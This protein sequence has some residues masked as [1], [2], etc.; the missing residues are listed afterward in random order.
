MSAAQRKSFL[1]SDTASMNVLR[2]TIRVHT[3]GGQVQQRLGL[4][5]GFIDDLVTHGDDWSF[6][7]KVS[8]LVET[9]VSDFLNRTI[10]QPALATD[11]TKL[12]LSRKIQWARKL[13][14]IAGTRQDFVSQLSELR[15]QLAHNIQKVPSFRL[16]NYL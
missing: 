12:P 6:V 16:A 15:N 1:Q 3:S 4:P 13:G 10:N 9:A 8:A 2:E 5:D 7:I 14:A 11:I